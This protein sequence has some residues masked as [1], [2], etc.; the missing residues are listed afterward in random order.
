MT[1]YLQ[2]CYIFRTQYASNVKPLSSHYFHDMY[3]QILA[4]KHEDI[5]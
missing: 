2:F 3:S 1:Y 4:A 5:N